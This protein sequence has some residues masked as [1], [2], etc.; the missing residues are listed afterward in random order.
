MKS[1]IEQLFENAGV[2]LPNENSLGEKIIPD[3]DPE[4]IANFWNWFGDS[5]AV[6]GYGRPIVFY[7]GTSSSINGKEQPEFDSFDRGKLG[8]KSHFSSK[9]GFFF[10]SSEDMAKNFGNIVKA[11]YLKMEKP[12]TYVCGSNVSS[13]LEDEYYKEH[14]KEDYYS[15]ARPLRELQKHTDSYDKFVAD[16]YHK[17]G[18]IP[19]WTTYEN[20]FYD[21]YNLGNKKDEYVNNYVS[22]LKSEGYD[23]IIIKDTIADKSTNSGYRTTQY[24]VLEPNQIKAVKNNGLFSSASNNIYESIEY[25]VMRDD[26]LG[27]LKEDKI[28]NENLIAYHGSAKKFD[29]FSLDFVGTG[30]H[31]R[32]HGYGFLFSNKKD[33]AE[34]YN[35]GYLY[36]VSIPSDVCLIHEQDFIFEQ[37]FF[38]YYTFKEIADLYFKD[39]RYKWEDI[40][41]KFSGINFYFM[42]AEILGKNTN[43]KYNEKLASELFDSYGILGMCYNAVDSMYY[44][45]FNPKNIKIIDVEEKK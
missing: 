37:P 11:V 35:K 45:I 6:D 4:K 39:Y 9:V 27:L 21:A 5:K 7:H 23:S 17:N 33:V 19:Y 15:A 30:D 38:V 12:M 32:E 28:I 8:K 22:A 44:T 29:N 3:D 31:G 14:Y 2:N 18:D 36:T 20:S 42:I 24:C 40:T 13:E 25:E 16:I 41:T 34:K 1:D 26:D 10:S 43:Y